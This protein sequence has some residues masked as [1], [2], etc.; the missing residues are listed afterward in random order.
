MNGWTLRHFVVMLL[1]A[2][3]ARAVY[4]RAIGKDPFAAYGAGNGVLLI[5]FLAAVISPFVL[6]WRLWRRRSARSV[7]RLPE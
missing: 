7:D 2:Y 5:L 4:E 3:L 6:L 1:A